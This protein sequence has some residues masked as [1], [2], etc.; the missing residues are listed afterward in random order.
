[1]Y[2]SRNT[3][4]SFR[5]GSGSNQADDGINVKKPPDCFIGH[6][7]LGDG[8]MVVTDALEDERFHDNPMVTD[9]PKI[10]FYAGMPLQSAD[11]Q[12]TW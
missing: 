6:T 3:G 8:V 11:G 4:I 2:L 1:M 7:I 12:K 9:P 10:R 5:T